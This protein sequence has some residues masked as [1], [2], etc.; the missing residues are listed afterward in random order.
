MTRIL[1]IAGSL[2]RSSYNRGLIRAA[3][4]L[5]PEGTAFETFDV[6]SLPHYDA[7]LEALLEPAPV[8]ALKDA[9]RRADAIVISTPEYNHGV[10]GALKNAIDWASRP[11]AASVLRGKPVAIL[12]AGGRSGTSHAQEQLRRHL[13]ATRAEVVEQ[14]VLEISHAWEHFDGNGNLTTPELRD[15]VEQL[16]LAL[17]DRVTATVSV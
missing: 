10:P 4:E 17:T 1:G 14:P 5:A 16:M 8:E 13:R 2:R 9:I 6:R 3:A 15:Q 11:A 12:G 7:D